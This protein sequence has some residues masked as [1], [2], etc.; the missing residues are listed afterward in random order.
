MVLLFEITVKVLDLC[1]VPN[2][3]VTL[4]LYHCLLQLKIKEK[5]RMLIYSHLSLSDVQTG[6][7]KET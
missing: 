5:D 4:T 6:Y 7:E 2:L 1:V 3:V